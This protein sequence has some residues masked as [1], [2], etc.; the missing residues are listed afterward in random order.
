MGGF[1]QLRVLSCLIIFEEGEIAFEYN[2]MSK[3]TL[4]VKL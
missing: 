1:T 3:L 2:G 4:E